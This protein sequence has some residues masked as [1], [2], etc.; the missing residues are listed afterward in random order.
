MDLQ[1]LSDRIA[2]NADA[3]RYRDKLEG[4]LQYSQ[5]RVEELARQRRELRVE[6]MR[7]NHDVEKLENF[8]LTYLFYTI[9]GSR[10]QQ[11]EKERREFLAVKLKF[12]QI[13]GAIDELNLT[14]R[15]YE[16][17]IGQ[18]RDL[19]TERA[20]LLYEKEKL[21]R[22][23]NHRVVWELTEM[24]ERLGAMVAEKRELAEAVEAGVRTIQAFEPLISTLESASNWGTWDL[25]GGG[26][27]ATSIKHS[28]IDSAQIMIAEI[29]SHLHRFETELRDVGVSGNM[30]IELSDFERFADYFFDGLIVDWTVLNK[31][32][33]SLDNAKSKH[34]AVVRIVRDLEARLVDIDLKKTALERER[35]ELIATA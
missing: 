12:D 3:I 29:Q 22:F 26:M 13:K 32:D 28:E 30:Q 4:D 10:E 19:E 11:L 15:D 7:E 8:G 16:E 9:L 33:K 14:I 34:R 18:L 25:I 6:A 21:L 2:Q 17:R 1:E 5:L 20:S 31:I 23:Q 27:L 35:N 24:S